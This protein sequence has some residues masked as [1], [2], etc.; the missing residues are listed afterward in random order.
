M[1]NGT[2]EQ[3]AAAA[4][5]RFKTKSIDLGDGVSVTVRELTRNE[6]K[7]LNDRLYEKGPDGKFVVV[8]E[9]NQP[10]TGEDGFFKFREGVNFRREWLAATMT[11]CDAIDGIL[12]DD[13][14][15]SVQNEI[16]DAARELNG[17][18]VKDAAK[19]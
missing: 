10:T 11:P 3:I 13:V 5:K 6:I 7:A 19:N 8:D 1:A 15:G 16:L 17:I 4:H 9:K 12:S 18:T 14:P 2:K